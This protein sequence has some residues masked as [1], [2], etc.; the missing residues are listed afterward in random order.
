MSNCD[1]KCTDCG[2]VSRITLEVVDGDG[3][4]HASNV[5]VS[6]EM[7]FGGA[8]VSQNAAIAN[9]SS[10][11]AKIIAENCQDDDPMAMA[12]SVAG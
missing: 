3:N 1:I 2:Y 6:P 10:E 8:M 11:W 5:N 4:V 7:T 9:L 12:A